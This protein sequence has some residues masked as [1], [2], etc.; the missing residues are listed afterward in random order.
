MKNIIKQEI[1]TL[2]D[3]TKL[4]ELPIYF[5]HLTEIKFS[6]SNTQSVIVASSNK[7]QTEKHK[8][9]NFFKPIVKILT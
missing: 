1:K 4:E 7:H 6:D 2:E 5:K 3:I 8:L 9:S